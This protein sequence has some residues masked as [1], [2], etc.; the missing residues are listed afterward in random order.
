MPPGRQLCISDM[1]YWNKALLAVFV[2]ERK[3]IEGIPSRVESFI[4]TVQCNKE[5]SCFQRDFV[6]IFTSTS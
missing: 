6:V 2:T 1:S 4:C 3:K 5:K